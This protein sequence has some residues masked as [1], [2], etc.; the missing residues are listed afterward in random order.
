MKFTH[1]DNNKHPNMVDVSEKVSGERSAVAECIVNLNKDTLE[2][3]AD[4]G[5]KSKKGA[6]LD[7]AIIAG[8]MAA[9]KTSELI[10]FCHPLKLQSVKIGISTTDNGRI[11]IE[12]RVKAFE[13]TNNGEKT[14]KTT[15]TKKYGNSVT[16][17]TCQEYSLTQ[18]SK[19]EALEEHSVTLFSKIT[20]NH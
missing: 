4:A 6:I 9:K 5:W 15:N 1:I 20:C 10:P 13:Q 12:A 2:S 19:V 18:F 3:F 7:T 11:R 17:H 8:T 14:S 16:P